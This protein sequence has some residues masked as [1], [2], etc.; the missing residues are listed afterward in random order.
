[1]ITENNI[2]PKALELARL[3]SL[4]IRKS[5]EHDT[6]SIV[7]TPKHRKIQYS[8]TY[9]NGLVWSL[10]VVDEFTDLNEET[11]IA[12]DDITY[13]PIIQELHSA[14]FRVRIHGT[15][16][17]E[18]R[19]FVNNE[20]IKEDILKEINECAEDGDMYKSLSPSN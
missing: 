13:K 19:L 10:N 20:L 4:E 17:K 18:L 6:I 3:F 15:D 11:F 12:I 9:I 5:E 16:K 2:P 1:M 7:S 8:S 14:K